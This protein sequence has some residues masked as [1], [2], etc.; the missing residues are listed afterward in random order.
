MTQ[1]WQKNLYGTAVRFSGVFGSF[2]YS[3]IFI[4]IDIFLGFKGLM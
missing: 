1:P 4:W 2:G 3:S